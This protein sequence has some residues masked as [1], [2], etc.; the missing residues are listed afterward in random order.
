MRSVPAQHTLIRTKGLMSGHD[1][2]AMV[3]ERGRRIAT[4]LYHSPL[5]W[6]MERDGR[7]R[8][9]IVDAQ[10]IRVHFHP[11]NIRLILR[12]LAAYNGE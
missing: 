5:P 10:G 3:Q 8:A 6:H 4:T 2:E 1:A 7:N 11:G 12:A 9:W